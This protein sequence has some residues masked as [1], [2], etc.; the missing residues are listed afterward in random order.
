MADALVLIADVPGSSS[1]SIEV[2]LESGVLTIQA[3]V[4][5]R[6]VEGSTVVAHEYG[7]GGFHRRFE[8]DESIDPEGVSA[9]YR[10]GSLTIRLPK[11]PRAQRRRVPVTT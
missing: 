6:G 3:S 9:E 2:S 10:D 11:A 8:I 1:D 5:P 7:V 4:E